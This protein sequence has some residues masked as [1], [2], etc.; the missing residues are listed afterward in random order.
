LTLMRLESVTRL[1]LPTSIRLLF[2]D[3]LLL[4]FVSVVVSFHF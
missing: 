3:L 2:S 4:N 1:L